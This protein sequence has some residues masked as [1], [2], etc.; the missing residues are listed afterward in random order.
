MVHTV[1]GFGIVNK[2]ESVLERKKESEVTQSCLTLYDPMDYR[3]PGFSIH[4]IF[5]GKCTG[6]GCHSP[7]DLPNPGIEPKSPTL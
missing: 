5:P 6:V 2:A 4:W 7:G 1:K 3:L